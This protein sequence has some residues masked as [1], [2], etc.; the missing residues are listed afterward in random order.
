[1]LRVRKP[2]SGERRVAAWVLLRTC[3]R[4]STGVVTL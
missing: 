4:G 1:M 3:V 2:A